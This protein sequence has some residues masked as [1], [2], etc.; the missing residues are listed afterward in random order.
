MDRAASWDHQMDCGPH[1]VWRRGTDAG[2]RAG[3]GLRRD[4]AGVFQYRPTI[5]GDLWRDWLYHPLG[6]VE[7]GRGRRAAWP[8]LVG[9][10][11]DHR[12]P[13]RTAHRIPSGHH[14]RLVLCHGTA[15]QS[16]HLGRGWHRGRRSADLQVLGA[17][18]W[19]F[20]RC[21]RRHQ[22]G[23]QTIG[24]G[25]PCRVG[26]AGGSDLAGDRCPQELFFVDRA[27]LQASGRRGRPCREHGQACRPGHRQ[28]HQMD[29]G[30]PVQA[31]W[32]GQIDH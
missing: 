6:A 12:W 28:C 11:G 23:A 14:Q 32:P 30:Y 5:R 17:D 31:R 4:A 1:L 26:S 24:T 13:G 2:G 9:L 7:H 19:V 10:V 15:G 25:I 8:G 20:P 21:L 22:R 18:L 27:A 3:D 16:A 29:P